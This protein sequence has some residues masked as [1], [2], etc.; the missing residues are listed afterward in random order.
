MTVIASSA[1]TG[2]QFLRGGSDGP[3]LGD[4]ITR[5][6]VAVVATRPQATRRRMLEFGPQLD[7]QA[8]GDT[9]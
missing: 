8:A 6:L 5:R 2:S 1:L 4:Q 7:G 9:A 3:E